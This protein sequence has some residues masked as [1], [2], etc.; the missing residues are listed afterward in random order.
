MKNIIVALALS[1]VCVFANSEE[2]KFSNISDMIEEF[3]DYSNSNGTYKI[4]SLSPLHIQLS[5]MVVAGDF[6]EVIEEMIKRA[7]IYGVYRSFIHTDI[8]QITVTAIP[9]EINF[10]GGKPRY[11]KGYE[12]TFSINRDNAQQLVQKYLKVSKLS[13]LITSVKISDM[14]I[15][16][17]WTKDFNRIYYNDQGY[18]GITKFFG[19]LVK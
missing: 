19:D 2:S 15:N 5:P 1:L 3:S 7:M 10:K 4:L 16:D 9:M 11:L 12:R 6:P 14:N 13:Q 18:P 8:N 17:Q